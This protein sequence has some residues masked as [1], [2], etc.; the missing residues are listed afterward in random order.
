MIIQSEDPLPFLQ[1]VIDRGRDL[2]G[3]EAGFRKDL[4]GAGGGAGAG[5]CIHSP[6]EVKRPWRGARNM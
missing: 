2:A 5:D 1:L 4:A 3:A 6:V